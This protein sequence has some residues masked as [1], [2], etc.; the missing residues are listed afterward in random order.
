M[1]NTLSIYL[2]LQNQL[3][4]LRKQQLEIKKQCANI[5]QELLTY[6]TDNNVDKLSYNQ[7]EIILYDKK[8]NMTFKKENLVDTISQELKDAAKAETIVEKIVSNKVFD[9][10]KSVKVKKSK[11]M[12][13]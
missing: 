3:K 7:N 10:H 13:Q 1:E 11:S 12:R 2:N 9:T 5:E 6:M 8:V 4:E